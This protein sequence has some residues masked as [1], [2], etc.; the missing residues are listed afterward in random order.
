MLVYSPY[1]LKEYHH[2]DRVE[3]GFLVLLPSYRIGEVQTS[4]SY[5][6][7]FDDYVNQ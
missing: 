5:H 1:Q 2:I 7:H 6:V 4:M 3:Q